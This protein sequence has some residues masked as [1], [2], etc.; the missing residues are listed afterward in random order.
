MEFK[1]IFA[2]ALVYLFG[3]VCTSDYCLGRYEHC[4]CNE[5]YVACHNEDT[6]SNIMKFITN[7]QD[8]VTFINITGCKNLVE[9]PPNTFGSCRGASDLILHKLKS[10]DFSDNN[11]QIIH[12]KSFHC[13]PHLTFLNL[14][15]N[16]WRVDLH[17]DQIG[18]FTSM[19]EL[20]HLDLTNTFHE[21]WNGSYHIPK[22]ADIFSLTDMT[23][24]ESLYLGRNELFSFSE[25]AANAFCEL[26]A[27]KLLDLSHNMLDKPSLP[28][29]PNCLE[30][31]R[32]ID[33]SF[34][35]INYL[36]VDFMSKMEHLK[37]LQKVRLDN[38][39][40][41]CDCGL[42]ETWDWITTTNIPI[43][44]D[45]ML[46]ASGYHSS[47]IN[48]PIIHL[49]RSDLKCQ[50]RKQPSNVAVKVVT[51]IIFGVIGLTLIAFMIVHRERVRLM[52]RRVQQRLPNVQFRSH[53][54]YA[55]VQEVA[56]I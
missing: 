56:T 10:V 50:P 47:Y 9:L 17:P 18:Y 2:C 7:I 29:S 20:Q 15:H 51:G 11:I 41:A 13:L 32:K 22:L 42:I 25:S 5:Q 37:N 3:Y 52:C 12:G 4:I 48:K 1:L 27:L 54:G 28:I 19:P 31:L 43:N 30:E 14:S 21:M 53:Q 16:Q 35:K 46:C 26:R 55:S 23:K 38:N 49:K 39:P 33:L 34:N 8:N 40:Y 36:P 24:L 6:L 44:K 45:E